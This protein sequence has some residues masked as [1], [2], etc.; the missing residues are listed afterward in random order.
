MKRNRFIWFLYLISFLLSCEQEA[1]QPSPVQKPWAS[2]GRLSGVET[3]V[4]AGQGLPLRIFMF[5]EDAQALMVLSNGTQIYSDLVHHGDDVEVPSHLFTR[6][7][8]LELRLTAPDS[9]LFRETV[10]IRAGSTLSD[11]ES[12]MG[13][14]TILLDGRQETMYVALPMDKFGNP[15]NTGTDVQLSSKYPQSFPEKYSEPTE[16]LFTAQ[17]YP[18]DGEIGEI[19]F[20]AESNAAFAEEQRAVIT[21]FWPDELFIV[22]NSFDVL[23]DRRSFTQ[24][25]TDVVRDYRGN[26]IPDGTVL[27]L[28]VRENGKQVARLKSMTVNGIAYFS[29]LHPENPGVQIFQVVTEHGLGSNEIEISFGSGISDFTLIY[30]RADKRVEVGPVFN[31]LGQ[32]VPDGTMAEFRFE[33]GGDERIE[34]VEIVNGTCAFDVNTDL[35]Y[36]QISVTI[37]NLSKSLSIHYE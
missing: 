5:P 1:E 13:P 11:I 28:I 6:S 27:F 35:L 21:P 24:I 12:F 30:D 32:L 9:L 7:G 14:K 15:A 29:V 2:I 10:D 17:K 16:H 23:A 33:V 20:G 34:N 8:S 4:T 25:R 26:Y 3:S 19:L 36:N 22:A 18:S 31:R 37:Q